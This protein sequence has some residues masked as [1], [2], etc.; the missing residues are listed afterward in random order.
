MKLVVLTF[1]GRLCSLKILFPLIKKYKQYI[2]EYRIFI[3]TTIQSDIDYMEKFA[4]E[5]DF[6]KIIYL[7]INGKNIT[8]NS[9]KGLIWD[10]AYNLCQEKDTVYLK[11]DDD[12]VYFDESLF[13]EFIDYRINN[14]NIPILYPII[15]NN[16]ITTPILEKNGIYNPIIKSNILETWKNTYNRI[17]S[18]IIENKGQQL[19]IGDFVADNEILCPASWG[20]L[21]YCYDLHSQFLND[22]S[23]GNIEKYYLKNNTI[24]TYAEPVS[25]NVCSWLGDELQK[26]VK[27]YGTVNNDENYLSV[28]VPI[29]S[30]HNNEIYCKS[31]VSH[32]AYYKQR[33]L[34]LDNTDILD[35][36]YQFVKTV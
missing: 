21:Q 10:N 11:L 29:W 19:R 9:Q 17:K 20:N 16:T 2:H 6:V 13:T 32:Y 5:N 33:E 24:L 3:A 30:G 35:R 18:H 31:V 27:E 23:Q 26:Y 7:K 22:I 34:G 12:I 36:Y 4:N 25:I 14:R 28:Y 15:I 8:D 1:G